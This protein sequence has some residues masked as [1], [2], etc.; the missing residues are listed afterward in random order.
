MGTHI[1]L[2]LQ[3]RDDD[4]DAAAQLYRSLTP[5]ALHVKVSMCSFRFV[6]VVV[7]EKSIALF[8]ASR[9]WRSIYSYCCTKINT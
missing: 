7:T 1:C 9:C 6:V 3:M 2:R 5:L 4:V 8:C